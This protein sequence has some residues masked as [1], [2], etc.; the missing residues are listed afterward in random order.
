MLVVIAH[1]TGCKDDTVSQPPPIQWEQTSLDSSSVWTFAGVGSSLFA[2][3]GLGVFRSTDNGTSW[4]H[5]SSGL[6]YFNTSTGQIATAGVR[7]FAVLSDGIGGMN[8]FAGT[9]G[10]GMYRSTN[11]GSTWT[12]VNSG[13]TAASNFFDVR[14]LAASGTDLFA[15][16]VEDG[17]FLSTNNGTSWTP[18]NEG[19]TQRSVFSFVIKGTNIF[20]GTAQGVFLS[21][22]RGTTWIQT[23]GIEWNVTAF[24]LLDTNLFAGTYG[25]GVYLSTNN[26]TSW[27]AVN[28]GLTNIQVFSLAAIPAS[29]VSG[30][31][32]FAGTESEGIF[33]STNGG[34]SWTQFNSG[35]EPLRAATGTT[36]VHSLTASGSYLFAGTWRGGVWRRPL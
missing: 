12:Q 18:V 11:N 1:A 9:W 17:V 4:L 20:A 28:A 35:L 7:A 8:L 25:G 32:L 15:G 22:N 24:A 33:V 30:T 34:I 23:V 19:L 31:N 26:G 6:T 21:T 13:F 36:R 2:G 5:V 16:T 27:T 14:A 3:G 10:G 29:R